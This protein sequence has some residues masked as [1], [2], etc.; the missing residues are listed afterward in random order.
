MIQ[1]YKVISLNKERI[2]KLEEILCDSPIM[3]V[4]KLKKLKIKV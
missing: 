3:R 4:K 2:K 1:K